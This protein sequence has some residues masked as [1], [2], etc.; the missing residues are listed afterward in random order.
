[1]QSCAD[2]H[3]VHW[4][5]H[6]SVDSYLP[7]PLRHKTAHSDSCS[8]AP[9]HKHPLFIA[10]LLFSVFPCPFITSIPSR[11]SIR[12]PS[13]PILL[14]LPCL[15]FLL[16]PFYNCL[17]PFQSFPPSFPSF[18]R[19]IA[20][21]TSFPSIASISSILCMPSGPILPSHP[22]FFFPSPSLFGPLEAASRVPFEGALSLKP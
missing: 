4:H 21:I 11:S 22:S 5:K 16:I 18:L 17:D 7:S 3:S 1:M 9:L 2:S 8:F 13:F 19:S 14:L 12:V 20:S 6:M 10:F 15:E